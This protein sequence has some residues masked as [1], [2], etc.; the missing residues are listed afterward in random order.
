MLAG[1]RESP[2]G[3]S[4]DA[5]S[6]TSWKGNG[7]GTEEREV[8]L[9]FYFGGDK[10]A[11]TDEVWAAVSDY[12]KAKGL[13]VKFAVHFIP[14][15][16]MPE[17][18]LV[19]A[20][21]GDKWDLNFDTDSSFQQMASR[22][23]YMALDDLLPVYAP[24]LYEKYKSLDSLS[25]VKIDGQIVALPWTIKMNQRPFAGWRVDLAEKAGITREPGEVKTVE[26]VDVLLHQMKKAYPDSKL[27]RISALPFY[28]VR[29]EWVDL[30]FH[31]LGFYLNDPEVKIQAM[32]QQPFYREAAVMSKRW[33]DD[34]ILNRDAMID[35]EDG[36]ELWRNGR[37]LFTITSHEWAY[38]ADPGFVDPTFRQQMSLLYPDKKQINRIATANLVAINRN[39]DHAVQ[40]LRFLDMLETDQKL[41][42]LVIYGIEGETY[43]LRGEEAVYPSNMNFST[44]NYMDWGGQWAFWKPQFM[45]PTATY[46]VGFWQEEKKFAELP[47]N[48]DSPLAGLLLSDSAIRSEV[49]KRDQGYE[50]YGKPIEY[51]VVS[52]VDESVDA[53]RKM[54]IANG[55]P[56][57]LAE[58]QRQVDRF[59]NKNVHD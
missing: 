8:T 4:I 37:M 52:Q 14:W 3:T 26:D 38:V 59:L 16:E 55:L 45:R 25:C 27:S 19:M 22:G 41:F 15:P 20:A 47:V 50:K 48:V 40:V 36:A 54:Q 32:E 18:L 33:F 10:K 7:T 43:E 44:S 9:Q 46:P 35:T 51:G 56:H 58:V 34:K 28:E 57:I 17:K 49:E 21:S 39:S 1:C 5:P 53:Y 23:S 6:Q 13:N 2:A 24:N 42:D 11:A 30:G 12:V 29:D 31:G